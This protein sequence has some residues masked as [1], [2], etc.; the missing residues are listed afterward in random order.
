MSRVMD[1]AGGGFTERISDINDFQVLFQNDNIYSVPENFF[2][3]TGTDFYEY[4]DLQSGVT[5]TETASG[6]KDAISLLYSDEGVD[7]YVTYPFAEING[8]KVINNSNGINQTGPTWTLKVLITGAL[9]NLFSV[10]A[11]DLLM[12]E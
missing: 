8:Y 6:Q 7:Q 10:K 1:N 4:K 11:G 9:T 2:N 12:T 3:I 5:A